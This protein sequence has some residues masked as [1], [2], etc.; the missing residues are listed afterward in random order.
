MDIIEKVEKFYSGFR[1]DKGVIGKSV[2]GKNIYFFC[3]EKTQFPTLIVQGA[4]HGREYITSYLILKLIKDFNRRGKRGRVFFL[5]M[6][7]P[8]GVEISLT[9]NPLNKAN[10]NGVDLNVNFDA[11]WGAG[12]KN[13]RTAGSE[14][15]IGAFPFSEL[16]TRA[17][18]DFTNRIMP[19]FTVSYHSKGEEIYWN[20]KQDKWRR[21]RD[22]YFANKISKATSYPLITSLNSAGGYKDWCID[23][24]K[25]PALTIEVG[26]DNLMHPITEKH[27]KPIYKKNKNV[28]KIL[29]EI[30]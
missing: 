17:L 21:N 5:P 23:K 22:F 28:I 4:I 8:D 2:S 27:L 12:A 25:I 29:T 15:Y 9:K 6:T 30:L 26:S 20:F 10:L 3:I 13:V 19:D 7:N 24:L 18:R 14:N 11:D 16:E 1:G